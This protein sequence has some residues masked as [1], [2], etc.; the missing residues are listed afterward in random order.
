M[1]KNVFLLRHGQ[2]DWNKERRMQGHTDVPLNTEGQ[3]QAR[4]VQTLLEKLRIDY[5]VSSDLKRA[6]ETAQ[7]ATE[8]IQVP[9]VADQ[10]LREVHLGQLEGKT[11]LEI[12]NE[13]GIEAWNKWA[14][15]RLE[16]FSFSL[17]GGETGFQALERMHECLQ[18]NLQQSHIQNLLV[19]TH[20]LMLR[21]FLHQLRPDL[22]T[23]VQIPNCVVYKVQWDLQSKKF[24]F[25]E[26]EPLK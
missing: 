22:D 26:L 15:H 16:D 19:T 24:S 8:G 2:T 13:F 10:R 23:P 25:L 21:R 6:Y 20:G 4:S 9:L 11:A 14:S 18:E 17:S 3:S 7:I 1:L 12:Q 5:V